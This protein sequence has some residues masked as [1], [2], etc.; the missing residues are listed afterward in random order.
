[1][2]P[3]SFTTDHVA[4]ILLYFT[5]WWG[6][7]LLLSMQGTSGL[8]KGFLLQRVLDIF[9]RMQCTIPRICGQSG[10]WQLR[11]WKWYLCL[12]IRCVQ[13]IVKQITAWESFFSFNQRYM[14]MIPRQ[15]VILEETVCKC[16]LQPNYCCYQLA[17]SPGYVGFLGSVQLKHELKMS[18]CFQFRLGQRGSVL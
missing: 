15:N 1:M 9:V 17:A 4:C 7:M 5:Q 13:E 8:W 6:A 14:G 3:F 16:P 18:L 12:T 11:I 2:F 10:C